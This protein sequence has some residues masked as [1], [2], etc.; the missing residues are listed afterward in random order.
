M[1]KFVTSNLK[2]MN[3]HTMCVPLNVLELVL[4]KI[5]AHLTTIIA[6][7]SAKPWTEPVRVGV[8]ESLCEATVHD[9]D[10]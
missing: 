2:T 10:S 6:Q 3:R 5:Q 9:L 8:H 4:V 1:F 7:K